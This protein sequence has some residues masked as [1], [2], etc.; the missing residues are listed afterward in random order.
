M[1][2]P[3]EAI[4]VLRDAS[5]RPD[6]ERDY[7][8]LAGGFVWSDEG[9]SEAARVSVE[10][11]NSA[12]MVI[13]YRA[14]LIVGEPRVE[15]T[16]PWEQLLL[17]CPD[18]PGFRVERVNPALRDELNAV[19]EESLKQ[20]EHVFRVCDRAERINAIRVARSKAKKWWR[21]W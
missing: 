17:A 15:L 2:F 8:L 12:R 20:L 9:L 19:G 1:L 14:S 18:W 10:A 13:G 6:A 21:F 3:D 4:A 16:E 7:D 11:S 5:W